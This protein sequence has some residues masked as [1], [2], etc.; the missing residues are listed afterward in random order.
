MEKQNL[1][2]K[3]IEIIGLNPLAAACSVTRQGIKRWQKNGRVPKSDFV[4]ETNYCDIIEVES[5]GKIT[6]E[7][8]LN[9]ANISPTLS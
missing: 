3:A 9:P 2:T 6:R 1:I 7:E 4:W 8:L 5:L